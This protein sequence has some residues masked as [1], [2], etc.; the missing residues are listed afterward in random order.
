MAELDMQQLH[1][2][3]LEI[4]I[5]LE[6]EAKFARLGAGFDNMQEALNEVVRQYRFLSDEGFSRSRVTG[7][8]PVWTLTGRRVW[9]D[10]A[11]DFIFSKKYEIGSGRETQ[12]RVTYSAAGRQYEITF[13]CVLANLQ[14]L[15][16]AADDNSA[17][18]VEL[19]VCGKPVLS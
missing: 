11:Q 4:N 2:V 13:D 6:G 15:G 7:L 9:G 19:H 18:T 3:R 17:V 12:A 8:A 14:E 10:P 16:G 5:S 1:A